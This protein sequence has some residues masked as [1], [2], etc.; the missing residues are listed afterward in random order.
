MR[1]TKLTVFAGVEIY[2]VTDRAGRCVIENSSSLPLSVLAALTVVNFLFLSSTIL[3][4]SATATPFW[5]PVIITLTKLDKMV[6]K[7]NT[8]DHLVLVL[9]L[10]KSL[11]CVFWG[12]VGGDTKG[13]E[14]LVAFHEQKQLT[15]H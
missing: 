14:V 11:I 5:N 15:E 6:Q 13:S 9:P 12:G 8:I 7:L 2:I 10:S 3:S 4:V 1:N